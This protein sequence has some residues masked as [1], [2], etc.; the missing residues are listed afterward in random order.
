MNNSKYW[1]L[2][3]M[4]NPMYWILAGMNNPKFVGMNNPK[5]WI[6]VGMN[7]PMYW[8]LVGMNNPMYWILVGMKPQYD[9]MS[10]NSLYLQGRGPQTQQSKAVYE[11]EATGRIQQDSEG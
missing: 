6:L 5:Y 4:N 7:N 9:S 10:L 11:A 3:G 8:I 1:I 2:V